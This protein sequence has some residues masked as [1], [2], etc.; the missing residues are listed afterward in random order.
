MT[1]TESKTTYL[2][3]LCFSSSVGDGKQKMQDSKSF[4]MHLA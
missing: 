2:F 1:T 3:R 4:Y